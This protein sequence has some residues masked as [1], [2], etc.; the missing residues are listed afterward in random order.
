M[1]P[2]TGQPDMAKVKNIDIRI[3]STPK[4]DFDR[5]VLVPLHTAQAKAEADRVAAERAAAEQAR[6]LELSREVQVA[7]VSA[8]IPSGS[9]TDWMAQAGIDPSNW[10]YVDYIVTRESGWRPD[11]VN[12]NGGACGLGQQLPCGKWVGA[13]NDPIAALVAMQGYC[14]SRYGG[15]AGAYQYWVGHGNY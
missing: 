11:A 7:R 12:P 6:Q 9:H 8:V 14:D 1:V 2:A 13:W 3:P 5:D 10:G 15:W 4:P